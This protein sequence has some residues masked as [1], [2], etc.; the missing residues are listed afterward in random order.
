MR[1]DFARLEKRRLRAAAL[2]EDGSSQAEVAADLAV[3]RQSVSRWYR[4]WRKSGEGGL[5][6][7]GRAG[8]LARLS[9]TQRSELEKALVAGPRAAGYSTELWTLP[10]V[11][12]LIRQL[13]MVSYHPGHVWRVLRKLGW[14][15]QRP[16]TRAKERDEEAI[17]QWR[18]LTWP[19][20]KKGRHDAGPH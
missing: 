8:R 11:A 9:V 19:R 6:A 20:I 15:C 10:R 7:A 12:K 1:R 13:C 18:R 4:D 5:K 17:R 16:A 2:F 3:S 14:S